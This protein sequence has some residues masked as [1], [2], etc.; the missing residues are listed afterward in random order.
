MWHW[1]ITGSLEFILCMVIRS[2]ILFS[3]RPGQ[4]QPSAAE[5]A[6]SIRVDELSRSSMYTFLDNDNSDEENWDKTEPILILF[7]V[8]YI[9]C[10]N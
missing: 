3:V 8:F 2:R 7:F 1:R 4:V 6:Q 10:N 9:W 5:I